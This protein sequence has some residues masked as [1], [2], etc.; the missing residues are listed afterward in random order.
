MKENLANVIKERKI[1]KTCTCTHNTVVKCMG[2]Q[3]KKK[4][5]GESGH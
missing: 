5:L 2:G 1:K 4:K 3:K